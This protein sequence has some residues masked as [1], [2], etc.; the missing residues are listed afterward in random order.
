MTP[1]HS[2]HPCD[3]CDRTCCSP[4]S[5]DRSMTDSCDRAVAQTDVTDYLGRDLLLISCFLVLKQTQGKKRSSTLTCWAIAKLT[6]SW[7]GPFA[8]ERANS[9]LM[10]FLMKQTGDPISQALK[11]KKVRISDDPA[12]WLRKAIRSIRRQKPRCHV[13]LPQA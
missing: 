13:G 12:P 7:L 5:C 4:G 8:S 11:K 10:S 1:S 6:P 3:S 9:H 2:H